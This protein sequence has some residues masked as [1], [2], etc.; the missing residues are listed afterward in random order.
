MGAPML[1]AVSLFSN[2]GAGDIGYAKAGFHFDVMAELDR[3]R[4]EVCLLNHPAAKGVPGDLRETWPAVVA[5]YRS[6]AKGAAPALLAACPPCQGMSSARSDRGKAGD[7]DAGMKDDRNLLVTV[8]SKVAGELRPRAIVVEN[9]QAF[10]TRQVRH[11]VTKAPVS[12]AR[13][14]I[15][16][17]ADEYAVFPFVTDLCDY[18][19]PQTRKR[20]FLTFVRL[21]EPARVILEERAASPYPLPRHS[22]EYKGRPITL[23]EALAAFNLPSLDAR[24][25][26][27]A[28][29]RV[30]KGLHAVPVWPDRRYDMVAAIPPHAG[31]S[32]WQN[33]ACPNCGRVKVGDA[34]AVCPQCGEP[35]LRP[36]VKNKR[37]KYRLIT[38]FRTSTYARMTSDA[39]A[40]TITT[41]SGHLG[42][43]NTIHPFENRLLSTLECA[44]LQTLPRRFKWGTALEQWGHTNIRD[45]IGEAVPPL[46]TRLHGKVLR[47]LLEGKWRSRLYPA[48]GKRC[49]RPARKL[50]LAVN[51]KLA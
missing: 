15:D 21:D 40:A 51:G 29:S 43:N 27:T 17:L 20:A 34:D 2:C 8:I 18:G 50:G 30:G 19:V 10:L 44:L 12:A 49:M 38:G 13:W 7:P 47:A 6:L 36:V 28:I 14:L 3:R 9:V 45:M 41:A 37:G 25:P 23:R 31:M 46:F 4:L 1:H 35:L 33:D 42:S 26:E 5:K 48:S 11:P 24:S 22:L 16:E 39:P 32:A